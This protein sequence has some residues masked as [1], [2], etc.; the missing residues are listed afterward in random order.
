[1]SI[2]PCSSAK[3]QQSDILLPIFRLTSGAEVLSLFNK[4]RV[5]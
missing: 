2:L 5:V 4:R 1:M 3:Y